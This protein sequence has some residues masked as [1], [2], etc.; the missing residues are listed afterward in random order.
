M[1]SSQA[2]HPIQRAER[3]RQ[4]SYEIRG[5]V[6]QRALAMEAQGTNIIKLNLG[7]PAPFGMVAPDALLHE[8]R[9]H[10][11]AASGYSESKG[12]LPARE[13]IVRYAQKK[14]IPVDSPHDVF[15]GNGVSELILMVMQGLLNPDDEILVP[16]PDYPL[17]TAAVRLAGG[18]AVHYR[19]EESL[20]WAPNLEDIRAKISNKT[21]GMV[22]INPNN[23]TGAVYSQDILLAMAALAQEHGLMVFSDE[24]YDQ[25]V[26]DGIAHHSIAALAPD[27]FC[28]TFNGLSKN[29]RAAGFRAG[30]CILSGERAH[31]QDF[32]DGL[33]ALSSMRLCA[34]VP[35][36]YTIKTALE[37]EHS[38]LDMVKPD[39][40]LCRQ[41]DLVFER[42]NTMP[43][44]SCTKPQGALYA[45]PRLDL[46][47]FNID[48]DQNMALK[49][50]EE[51]HVLIVHGSGFNWP[52]FDHFRV[53]FLPEE[54]LLNEALERMGNFFAGIYQA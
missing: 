53:V 31:A 22:L 5:P 6:M 14:H 47:H 18:R 12:I 10:L 36:Q 38:I 26:Y 28:L 7:N 24:I 50:L 39:G 21:R 46:Q 9:A 43:G 20:N 27:V 51:S 52:A 29:Y 45:F 17:W 33:T 15:I 42:L 19:C 25:I 13:A 32:I 30:W 37:Q 1:N 44:L 23:P 41:R 2:P 48:H 8:M 4:V 16:S 3:L 11:H 35:A 40:R 49:L 54:R 34:N